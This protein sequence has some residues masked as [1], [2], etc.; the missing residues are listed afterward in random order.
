MEVPFGRMKIPA[1]LFSSIF[2]KFKVVLATKLSSGH[3]ILEP[4]P[5]VNCAMENVFEILKK[6]AFCVKKPARVNEFGFFPPNHGSVKEKLYD[7]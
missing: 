1:K 2:C 5:T 6:L 3:F 4:R 7:W